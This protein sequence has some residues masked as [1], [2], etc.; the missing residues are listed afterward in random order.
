MITNTETLHAAATNHP[1]TPGETVTVTAETAGAVLAENTREVSGRILPW[2]K[3][4]RTSGGPLQFAA[5]GIRVPTDISRIKLLA[6]HSPNGIPIGHA[7]GWSSDADGLNMTF[8]IGTSAAADAALT[9]LTERTVDAFSVEASITDRNGTTITDGVLTAVALVPVPAFADA[10]V[11]TVQAALGTTDADTGDPG[12]P[13]PTEPTTPD[14][15]DTDTP[16]DTPEDKDPDMTKLNN[17]IIPGAGKTAPAAAPAAT[18][19]DVTAALSGIIRG[20]LDAP[21]VLAELTGITESGTLEK[22]APAWL[23]ELW[24]GVAYTREIIPLMTQSPLTSRKVKGYRWKTKPGV[25]AYAGDL[26]EIPTFP[27]ELEEVERAAERIAGGNRLDRIFW[28]FP[29]AQ[30]L[31]AY[32]AAMAESYAYQTDKAAAAFLVANA[33]AIDGGADNIIR[34]A[35]QGANAIRNDLHSPAD[36]VMINPTDKLSILEM[37]VMD[38]P[39]FMDKIPFLDPSSWTESEFVESGTMVIGARSAATHYEL[40]GSPIRVEAEALANG[41]RD[42]ALFGYTAKMVNKAEGIRS[43]KFDVTAPVT[44]PT[45]G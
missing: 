2:M 7:T 36:W 39:L 13:E 35:L 4:G 33:N 42:A 44:P 1:D 31:A 34:A 16:D 40:G 15:G 30:F 20:D 23:G 11:A 18:V 38:K 21:T 10:R 3:F 24:N 5:G 29:D 37:T 27:V 45:E 26:A 8:S 32:W 28:D 41:G 9:D 6:G 12:R 19:A 25:A 14:D 43:I 22:N 17:G